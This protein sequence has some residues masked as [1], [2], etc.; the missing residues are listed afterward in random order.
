MNS[1]IPPLCRNPACHHEPFRAGIP[2]ILRLRIR[3]YHVMREC[4]D[5]SRIVVPAGFV[6]IIYVVHQS[7][8]VLLAQARIR[9]RPPSQRHQRFGG[10]PLGS[11]LMH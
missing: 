11:K 3:L 7:R 5:F 8:V 9:A 1:A 2:H 6:E 4:G 10:D